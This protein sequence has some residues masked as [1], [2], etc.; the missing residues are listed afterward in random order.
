M[1]ITLKINKRTKAGRAFLAMLDVFVKDSKGVE[2]ISADSKVSES[3]SPYDPEFV[4]MVK[5]AAASKE[6]YEI[7][8]DDIWGSL[9]LE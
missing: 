6:R 9:G 3:E 1:E 7:D 8:P 2:V 4:K 5:E